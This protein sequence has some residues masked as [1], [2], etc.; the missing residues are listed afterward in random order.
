VYV[1]WFSSLRTISPFTIASLK[2]V[3]DTIFHIRINLRES[4]RSVREH[5][6]DAESTRPLR[7]SCESAKSLQEVAGNLQV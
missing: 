3:L 6:R 1:V 7:E 5:L 4:V 2:Q